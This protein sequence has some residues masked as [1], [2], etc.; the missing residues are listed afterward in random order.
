M[1]LFKL[2]KRGKYL[3]SVFRSGL[4]FS[5]W[6]NKTQMSHCFHS[7]MMKA[8]DDGRQNLEYPKS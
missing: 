8:Q 7:A 5:I 1:K 6:W 2:Q 4:R 3:N